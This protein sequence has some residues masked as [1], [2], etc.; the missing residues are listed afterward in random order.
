MTAIIG[1]LCSDGVVVGA[2][3][4]ATFGPHP[5][6]KTIEQ[7][8]QKIEIVADKIILTGT[9]E[10]GLGQRFHRIVE[11]AW[12]NGIFKN[13]TGGAKPAMTAIDAGVKL[14][15]AMHES[16]QATRVEKNRYGAILAFPCHKKLF[17][18]EFSIETFQPELKKDPPG[19]WW[20]SMG[21]GQPITDPFL[22]L[23][24][25]AMWPSSQPNVRAG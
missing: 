25:E 3:S 1:M 7:P 13:P 24:R 17:L 22:A 15:Q 12:A 4:S 23:L 6:I 20:T 9:G 16:L 8:I 14:S 19:L 21:S 2:D 18:T 11:Q 5:Q 10:V